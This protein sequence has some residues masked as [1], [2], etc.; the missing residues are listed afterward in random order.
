MPESKCVPSTVEASTS[1]LFLPIGRA[2]LREPS[3]VTFSNPS[4][5][6][7][8]FIERNDL[9]VLPGANCANF[10]LR[11]HRRQQLNNVSHIAIRITQTFGS[12]IAAIKKVQVWGQPSASCPKHLLQIIKTIIQKPDRTCHYNTEELTDMSVPT[13]Q[14][15]DQPDRSSGSAMNDADIPDEFLDPL[16]L[17]L[18]SLPMLLPSGH[19]VDQLTLDRHAAAE[20]SWGRPPCDP[21]TGVAFTQQSKP[22]LNTHL[23]ARIDRYILHNP[24]CRHVIGAGRTLG[25]RSDAQNRDIIGYSSVIPKKGSHALNQ[26]IICQQGIILDGKPAC[27]ENVD[28]VQTSNRNIT[29]EPD[30]HYAVNHKRIKLEPSAVNSND[31]SSIGNRHPMQTSNITSHQERLSASLDSALLSTLQGLPSFRS[32]HGN[33]SAV[34]VSPNVTSE[35]KAHT[36]LVCKHSLEGPG[37]YR[38]PCSHNLCRKCLNT[39]NDYKG[40]YKCVQCQRHFSSKDISKLNLWSCHLANYQLQFWSILVNTICCV[41]FS[42]IF[43]YFHNL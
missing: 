6:P 20:N 24:H 15:S 18:M 17:E 35:P 30:P 7:R 16:T 23:K 38:L 14:T 1:G 10:E 42:E 4:Y 5:C 2:L 40:M 12:C 43:V 19:S 22:L 3:V 9:N 37:A 28:N 26:P 21:F 25:R 32:Y 8:A 13:M 27:H 41:K 39:Q 34:L 29:E 33:N 11:H 36:C 31:E